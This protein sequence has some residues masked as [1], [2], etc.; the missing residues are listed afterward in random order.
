M[1]RQYENYGQDQFNIENLHL[2]PSITGQ[3]LLN[4]G[5]QL[6]SQRDYQQA[7]YVLSNAIRIDPLLSDTHYYLAISLL[8]G[9][10]PRKVD[11]WT[12][13]DVQ[14]HLGVAIH[15][16][17]KPS[18]CYMLWAIIKHG[19]Y[20]MNGFRENP[21][22]SAQLLDLGESIQAKDAREILYHMNDPSNLCWLKLYDKFGKTH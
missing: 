10:R 20:T 7:A 21:P 15:K 13:R 3:E 8:R 16:D 22:T 2:A 5:I 17:T 19:F 1:T 11:E 18:R 14:E 6:L 4:I 9:K 12:I